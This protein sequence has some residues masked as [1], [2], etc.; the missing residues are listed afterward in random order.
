MSLSGFFKPDSGPP[1]A[2]YF[3]VNFTGMMGTIDSSFQEVSGLKATFGV[4]ERTEGGANR[5]VHR[6]R[7]LPNLKT[8]Y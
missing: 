7:L 1:T 2:F 6:F 3:S 5:F 4:E 8:L